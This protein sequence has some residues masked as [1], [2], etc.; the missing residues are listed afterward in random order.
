[1]GPKTTSILDELK[2]HFFIKEFQRPKKIKKKWKN[3][4][5]RPI[6][7][8]LVN[9]WSKILKC[10]EGT[11]KNLYLGWLKI[12]FFYKEFQRPKNNKKKWKNKSKSPIFL[13]LSIYMI[14]NT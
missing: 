9:I 2:F 11:K 5:K 12:P 10:R 7:L 13:K 6:F 3:K 14:Q 1:M 4:S 8:N